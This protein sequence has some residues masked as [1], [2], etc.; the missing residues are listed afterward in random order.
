MELFIKLAPVILIL[1]GII[2]VGIRIE[3][4]SQLHVKTIE[5]KKRYIQ[6]LNK[7]MFV[8]LLLM[9]IASSEQKD[10]AQCNLK[11][12]DLEKECNGT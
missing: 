5:C 11:A 1:A 3:K 10:R 12:F 7:T 2:A 6:L 4:F 8:Q 9:E